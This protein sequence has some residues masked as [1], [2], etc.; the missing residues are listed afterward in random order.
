MGYDFGMYVCGKTCVDVKRKRCMKK[1][2]WKGT[3][4]DSWE[5]KYGVI[6]VGNVK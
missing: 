1:F 5:K 4:M 6:D 3:K 2:Q